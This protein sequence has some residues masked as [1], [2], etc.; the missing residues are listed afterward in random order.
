[1]SG[2]LVLFHCESNT[3]Y[4]IGRLERVFFEM[5]LNVFGSPERIHFAYPG[6]DKGV[7]PVL[8]GR[9]KNIVKFD[10]RDASS[11]SADTITRYIKKHDISAVFGFDQ[12]IGVPIHRVLRKAGVQKFISYWGAPMS[13]VNHGFR[14]LAKR[15]QVA[16]TPYKPDL[17]I[18]ES[19]AMR[20]TAVAGRGVPQSATRVVY[21]GVDEKK[22]KPLEDKDF[23]YDLFNIPRGRKVIFYS[24]HMEERKGVHIIVKAAVDLVMNKGRRD[25]HFLLLGN[26]HG[27]ERRF[28][29]LYRHTEAA[30]H[31]TFGGYRKEV[32]KIMPCCYMGAIASTGW[33]SFPLSPLEMQSC[34]LPVIASALQGLKECI[35]DGVTGFSISPGAHLELSDRMMKLLSSPGLRERMSRAA[36]HRILDKFTAARQIQNLA[37]ILR[38]TVVCPITASQRRPESPVL[39]NS[40]HG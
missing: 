22:F 23:V 12:P 13:S 26:K 14:L 36:R 25:V 19:E 3:G 31:I 10:Y 30:E 18:L 2:L 17:F 8:E 16:L 21:N 32:E 38:E 5:G 27:E 9:L 34:G 15:I 7:D 33:D 40:P 39:E 37:D 20:E 4:A 29:S 11:R 35:E 24:G 6:I 1:M 28:D